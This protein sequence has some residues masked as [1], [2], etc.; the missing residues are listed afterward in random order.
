MS[1]NGDDARRDEL[2]AE[3]FASRVALHAGQ[4]VAGDIGRIVCLGL[5]A[6]MRPRI[7]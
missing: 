2:V 1:V 4:G 3:V 5:L 7:V 6:S